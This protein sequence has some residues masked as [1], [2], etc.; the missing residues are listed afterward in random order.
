MTVA[1]SAN[2]DA[3][4]IVANGVSRNFNFRI[5]TNSNASNV[6]VLVADT[7][8]KEASGYRTS[9]VKTAFGVS[10]TINPTPPAGY[11][12]TCF[13]L[14]L[15]NSPVPFT[16]KIRITP[17][18]LNPI[19]NQIYLDL[20]SLKA[21]VLRTC[22]RANVGDLQRD[23]ELPE[24]AELR[25]KLLGIGLDGEVEAIDK[26][27]LGG[28]G[29]TGPTTIT[30]QQV[31]QF[32]K[33]ILIAGT[34]IKLDD[35]DNVSRVRITQTG[36]IVLGNFTTDDLP[37]GTSNLYFTNTL[38]DNR[39]RQLINQNYINSL[40][41]DADNLDG[42]DGSFYLN[43]DNLTNK[44]DLLTD[45]G[46]ISVDTS[47][48]TRNL[49]ASDNTVQKA[50]DTLDQLVASG[51]SQGGGITDLSNF[52]TTDLAE[53]DN[54]YF[55]DA[56]AK[57]AIDKDTVD[58]L[59]VDADTLDGEHASFYRNWRN[60]TNK[61]AIPATSD[62]IVEGR[63]N[64]FLTNER[65]DDRVSQLLTAGTNITLNYDDAKNTLTINATGTS[66]S[67]ITDLSSFTTA[68]LAERTNLYFTVQRARN[69]MNKATIDALKIDADTLDGQHGSYYS[70]YD[71]L[72][73]KPTIPTAQ[74]IIDQLPSTALVTVGDDAPRKIENG[75]LWL[76]ST[77]LTLKAGYIDSN[78]DMQWVGI[79]GD[80]GPQGP[81]GVA[82]IQGP[83]GPA[84]PAG[85]ASLD[86]DDSFTSGTVSLARGSWV[87]IAS[88]N[89]EGN[90]TKVLLL[91]ECSIDR[92]RGAGTIS[93]RVR[94]GSTVIRMETEEVEVSGDA[95][96]EQAVL[97]M[98]DTP[99]EDVT[100]SIDVTHS[101]S[102]LQGTA[103]ARQI[104]AL[105]AG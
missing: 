62:D 91:F 81:E 34:N 14:G 18:N 65:I 70:D 87:Q 25:G 51:G 49:N 33:N 88:I 104:V 58:A 74:D 6:S 89:V 73:N 82:G 42:R 102:N 17:A 64:L 36:D 77:D 1:Q 101:S 31:Y 27:S 41:V 96:H 10:V 19:I 7:T 99:T 86:I 23:L 66:G 3:T 46:D 83:A 55:T 54:K 80:R 35:L 45:A 15:L 79:S 39:A 98:V 20:L 37:V 2:L 29:Q 94:R 71:N 72:T 5:Q 92:T 76:D 56:R 57:A 11:Y 43:Y 85:T 44:P 52:T 93:L 90:G 105:K 22:I 61:P 60:I 4:Q 63:S 30:E 100:Y 38:F 40:N 67:G 9:V 97:F 84:G 48:F 75:Q 68:D 12:I 16:D 78:N 53:G 50:F 32:V 69:A 95:E 103:H 47:T 21:L 8:G 13:P 59:N 26:S 28:G 24:F